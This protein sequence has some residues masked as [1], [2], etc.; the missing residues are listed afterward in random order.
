MNKK[1]IENFNKMRSALIEITNYQTPDK[2][3]KAAAYDW[4]IDFE[5]TLKMSYENM[6]QT[7]KLAV[8]H[9]RVINV[10]DDGLWEK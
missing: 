4:D 9:V 6:Q 3:R 10:V 5:E 7:A 1:Q 8:R 2:L